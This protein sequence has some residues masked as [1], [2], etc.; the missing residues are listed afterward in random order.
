MAWIV[1][2]PPSARHPYQRHQ[3]RYQDGNRQRSAGIFPTQR[4]AQAEKRA[5]E[6]GNRQQLPNPADLDPQEAR[7]SFGE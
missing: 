3:V 7:T 6:R 1:T 5:I 2:I 4:R